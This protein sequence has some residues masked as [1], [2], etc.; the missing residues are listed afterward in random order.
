MRQ[1]PERVRA[2]REAV[3]AI[4]AAALIGHL[5]FADESGPFVIPMTLA[6]FEGGVVLH[7]SPESRAMRVVV[8]GSPVCLEVTHVDGLVL[9]CRAMVHSMNYRSL[10]AFGRGRE[11]ADRA[12]KRAALGVL[13]HHLAP[14]RGASLPPTSDEE[15]DVTCVA[16]LAFD[17][18][19]VKTREGP[20]LLEREPSDPWTGVLPLRLVA[21]TPVPQAGAG[22]PPRQA[23]GWTPP[24]TRHAV[25]EESVGEYV[26]SDD[27]AR[28][29]PEAVHRYVSGESYWAGG[30]SRERQDEAI[31]NS[32]CVGAYHGT[33]QVGFARVVTDRV[34]FAYLCDVYVLAPHRGRGLAKRMVSQLRGRPDLAGVTRWMLGTRDAHTLYSSLG[35]TPVAEPERWMEIRLP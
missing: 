28:L 30:I 21:G 33:E 18:C 2:G 23:F 19:S 6:P 17:E 32:V 7:G 11:I 5:G 10:V 8:S 31:R 26:V 24:G 4:L 3:D 16:H 12:R 9:G 14:G 34:R 1:H 35:W 25:R 27:P 13:M 29:D 20:P 22:A 15:L